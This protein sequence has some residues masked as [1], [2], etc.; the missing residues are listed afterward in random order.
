MEIIIPLHSM[1]VG[2]PF[3][4]LM[5]SGALSC[6]PVG[7]KTYETKDNTGTGNGYSVTDAVCNWFW[8]VLLVSF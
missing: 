8:F 3:T 5:S 2:M 4:P 6:V 7:Y 1:Y